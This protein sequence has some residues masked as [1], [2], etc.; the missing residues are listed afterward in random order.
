MSKAI[1]QAF[2]VWRLQAFF[3]GIMI[4]GPVA[5]GGSLEG[6]ALEPHILS[7]APAQSPLH[8]PLSPAIAKGISAAWLATQRSV[9]VSGL[10]WYPMFAAFPGPMAP[11]TP[12]VPSPFLTLIQDMSATTA[13][14]LKQSMQKHLAGR[15]EFAAELLDAIATAFSLAITIW[16]ASQRSCW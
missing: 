3:K 14:A 6:P 8:G 10:P 15:T 11:P 4:N 13:T 16:R 7:F 2:D 1:V 9:S 5:V 12:N